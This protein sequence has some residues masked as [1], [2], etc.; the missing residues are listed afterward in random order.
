M[1]REL[2]ESHVAR[3]L[4]IIGEAVYRLPQSFK[5]AY[6]HVPWREVAAL[7]HIIVHDYWEL[8]YERLWSIV[9]DHLPA[10]KTE[11]RELLDSLPPADP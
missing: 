9:R 3:Q 10:F 4:E 6:P 7:R 5:K 1:E 2:I 11:I 8:D